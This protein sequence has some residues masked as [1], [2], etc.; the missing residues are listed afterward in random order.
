MDN[1]WKSETLKLSSLGELFHNYLFLG[2][3][4]PTDNTC[5]RIVCFTN[6]SHFGWLA[7]W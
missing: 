2:F 3:I 5:A 7:R 6:L 4:L 1:K